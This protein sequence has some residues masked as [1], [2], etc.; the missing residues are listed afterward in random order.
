MKDKLRLISAIAFFAI[1][2]SS[3]FLMSAAIN[4]ES[5]K[6]V[7]AALAGIGTTQAGFYPYCI[8]IISDGFRVLDDATNSIGYGSDS[9]FSGLWEDAQSQTVAQQFHNDEEALTW[10]E[11]IVEGATK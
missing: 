3:I 2:L 10:F 8:N 5:E 4:A 7:D 1:T 6:E 9:N 11:K